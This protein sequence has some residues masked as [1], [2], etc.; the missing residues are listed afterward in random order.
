MSYILRGNIGKINI[1]FLPSRDSNICL[2]LLDGLPS[3][4]PSKR[5]NMLKLAELWYSSIAPRYKWTRESKGTFLNKSPS[6]DILEVIRY[7]KKNPLLDTYNKKYYDFSNNLIVV[8][9][10]SFWGIVALDTVKYL[11]DLDYVILLSPLCDFKEMD[12]RLEPIA[13]FVKEGFW[14]AYNFKMENRIKMTKG[15]L[16]SPDENSVSKFSD[17]IT[18]IHDRSDTTIVSEDVISFCK[19]VKIKDIHEVDGIGHLSYNKRNDAVYS[20]ISKTISGKYTTSVW[21]IPVMLE[22]KKV[23]YLCIQTSDGMWWFPKWLH[24][25]AESW[26]ET[27]NRELYEETWIKEITLMK[28]LPPLGMTY[29]ATFNGKTYFKSNILFVGKLEKTMIDIDNKEVKK[30]Q[31]LEFKEVIKNIQYKKIKEYLK[32]AEKKWLATLPS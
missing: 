31:F 26:L 3:T 24:E 9:W 22:W 27:A 23:K 12:H 2:L 18:V 13:E 29:K 14:R 5:D 1:E 4:N 25:W 28:D 15:E 16:F 7:I 6:D 17:N 21:Y 11:G 32:Y 19:K 20:L 8:I 10:V 30:F